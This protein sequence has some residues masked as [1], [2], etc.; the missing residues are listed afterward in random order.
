MPI[1]VAHNGNS[2]NISWVDEFSILEGLAV[3]GN[4]NR[5]TACKKWQ[6]GQRWSASSRKWQST[7]HRRGGPS[8]LLGPGICGGC[9]GQWGQGAGLTTGLYAG[10]SRHSYLGLP[11]APPWASESVY[12]EAKITES[13]SKYKCWGLSRVEGCRERGKGGR[14]A[15]G[16]SKTNLGGKDKRPFQCSF[17]RRV[18]LETTL[19]QRIEPTW[20]TNESLAPNVS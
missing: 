17:P 19:I 6:L 8:A 14:E 1:V 7:L 13:H 4:A 9:H 12:I 10:G 2:I 15:G 11:V 16:C 3:G 20:N 18:A 5:A